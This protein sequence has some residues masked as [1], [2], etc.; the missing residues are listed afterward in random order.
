MIPRIAAPTV[1]LGPV[2]HL[3]PN[4]VQV[5]IPAQLAEI[6]FFFDQLSL[7]SPLK[8]MSH[9][10]VSA[11]EIARVATVEVLHSG[12][13]IGP[14]SSDKQVVMIGHQHKGVKMPLIGFHRPT[15]PVEPSHAILVVAHDVSPLDSA[16][17]HMTERPFVFNTQWPDHAPIVPDTPCRR[18]TI[19]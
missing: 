5:N 13:Q 19:H 12:R 18:N 11:I 15:Q 9:P 4:R 2:D 16:R 17:H 6:T 3:R 1:S 10:P 14:W 8:Q 7:K